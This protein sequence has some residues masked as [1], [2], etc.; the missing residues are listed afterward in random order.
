LRGG[1]LSA[2]LVGDPVLLPD[3][4]QLSVGVLEAVECVDVLPVHHLAFLGC[5][6]D[7]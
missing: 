1:H 7:V 4:E 3:V 5:D 2:A 6:R